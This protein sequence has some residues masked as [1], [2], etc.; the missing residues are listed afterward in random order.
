VAHYLFEARAAAAA[1]IGC[2][3]AV[4]PLIVGIKTDNVGL[5]TGAGA[6]SVRFVLASSQ[7]ASLTIGV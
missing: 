5:W 2:Y 6:A 3:G 7:I 4:I 1:R